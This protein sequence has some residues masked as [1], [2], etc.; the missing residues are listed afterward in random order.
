VKE[1]S[2]SISLHYHQ[3]DTEE[4]EQEEKKE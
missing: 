3:S 2:T 1:K 4:L